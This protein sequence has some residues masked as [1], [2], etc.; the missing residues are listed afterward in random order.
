MSIRPDTVRPAVA[1]GGASGH[2]HCPA[3]GGIVAAQA[4]ATDDRDRLRVL[5]VALAVCAVQPAFWVVKLLIATLNSPEPWFPDFF[6]LWSFGRYALT[7]AP[8]TIYDERL[9]HAFET[10]LG[11]PPDARHYSCFYP[12]WSLLLLVP[13]GALPYA[14]ARIAWLVLTFGMYAGALAAWRWQRPVFGLLLLAPSSAVC[15]LVGQNGFLTAALMLGG[16]H[17]LWTRPLTAGLMLGGLVC[18]PQ[19]AI[20]VPFVLLFGRHWR[21]TAGAIMCIAVMSLAAT[22]A[23]G[24]E[25]WDAWLQSILGQAGTLTAGRQRL[26]GMMPTLTSAVQQLGGTAAAA[27]IVQAAGGLGGVLALWRV[28]HCRD[29]EARAVLP[30][31]T[32]LATP[33]AFH[34]DL[35]MTTGAVLAVMA[36]RLSGRRFGPLEFPL[37]LA[38]IMVP[39][40][41][42]S[43]LGAMSAVVPA[44]FAATLWIMSDKAGR[45]CPVA[46]P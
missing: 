24:V 27:Y 11:M 38:C 14:V 5:R 34:Y 31:A 4:R 28:R 32:I 9:L 15:F 8:A 7:H 36:A 37:L 41:L 46:S 2:R 33:Y 20:L 45:L 16:M 10:A 40:A 3:A 22:L 35:P 26:F 19:F 29:A 23:F 39:A 44:I 30:L 21:A 6:G 25:T 1:A 43:H 17:L 12:P 42:T 18:K 13:A